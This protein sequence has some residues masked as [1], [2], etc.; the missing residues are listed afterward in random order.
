MEGRQMG[1]DPA[2]AILIVDDFATMSQI[3]RSLLERG[4][5]TNIEHVH[6]GQS[7]LDRLKSKDIS[8]IISDLHMA[9][10]SGLELL[11]RMHQELK[12]D[13]VRFILITADGNSQIPA[14]VRNPGIDGFL[15]KPF[16]AE[17]LKKT[18]EQAF[19]HAPQ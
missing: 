7:A 14:A 8:L 13:R 15:L 5:F 4:G 1:V 6:D 9:P 19:A 2:I 10:M 17:T 16:S 3:I 12:L 18:I 11:R